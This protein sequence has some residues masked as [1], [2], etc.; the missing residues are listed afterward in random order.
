[1]Q[2]DTFLHTHIIRHPCSIFLPLPLSLLLSNA[3]YLC[4]SCR[5]QLAC[6]FPFDDINLQ[7]QIMIHIFMRR[8]LRSPMYAMC[9]CGM[10]PK[11]D[12][13]SISVHTHSFAHSFAIA[14]IYFHIR[15]RERESSVLN[16][17]ISFRH[18]SNYRIFLHAARMLEARREISTHINKCP[19]I[20]SKTSRFLC[21]SVSFSLK[22]AQ[23]ISRK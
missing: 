8:L 12:L 17:I 20:I 2:C 10:Q 5:F 14:I 18:Y 11:N 15:E 4:L 3:L 22:M 1:M 23:N 16:H 21:A 19:N 7:R 6:D 13:N 9:V